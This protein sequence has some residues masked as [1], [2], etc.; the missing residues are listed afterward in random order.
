MSLLAVV[1]LGATVSLTP[2]PSLA[3]PG[4]KAVLAVPRSVQVSVGRDHVWG[5]VRATRLPE[6]VGK[7]SWAEFDRDGSGLLEGAEIRAVAAWIGEREVVHISIA[8]D[9]EVLRFPKFPK[10]YTGDDSVPLRLDAAVSVRVEG[11]RNV[12]L[13]P[14]VHRY[15]LYDVPPD[16]GGFV[17]IRMT[18]VKGFRMGEAQGTRGERRGERRLE[19]TTTAFTPAMWGTFER[20]VPTGPK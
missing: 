12:A 11:R 13:A 4:E 18:F 1:A 3:G 19:V 5:S 10:K 14:G 15:V 9:G 7:E 8:V 6:T 2:A 20:M 17:P 16:A